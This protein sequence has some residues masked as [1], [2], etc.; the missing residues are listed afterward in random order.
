MAVFQGFQGA[1][2]VL[3]GVFERMGKGRFCH[4]LGGCCH[5]LSTFRVP[6]WE[7]PERTHQAL[8]NREA[9]T[10]MAARRRTPGAGSVFRDKNGTW[11]YRKDLGVDPATGKRRML[12]AKGSTKAEARERFEAKLDDGA[13]RPCAGCEVTVSGRLHGTLAEGLPDAR[14]TEHVPHPRGA[15]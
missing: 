4:V 11:H 14:Q 12:Q 2:T 1:E 7:R 10:I 15:G 6:L 8:P 13:Y 3:F 5:C 9:K